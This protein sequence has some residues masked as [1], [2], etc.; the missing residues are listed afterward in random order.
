MHSV[1]NVQ[2]HQILIARP[3]NHQISF[4]SQLNVWLAV[5]IF[6]TATRMTSVS[7]AIRHAPLVEA[8]LTLTASLASRTISFT[9]R[10]VFHLVLTD[11]T[12]TQVMGTAKLVMEDAELAQTREMVL[13]LIATMD[14]AKIR[15]EL[16]SVPSNI[17]SI[18]QPMLAKVNFYQ[19]IE[20]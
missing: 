17:S 9:A 18:L 7:S 10:S 1:N 6:I 2:V 13:A 15:M 20:T 11:I 16:A 4:T 3:A 8:L 19:F 12:E 5:Q 14:K